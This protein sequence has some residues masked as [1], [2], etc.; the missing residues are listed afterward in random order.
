M[1]PPPPPKVRRNTRGMSALYNEQPPQP[2]YQPPPPHSPAPAGELYPG[3]SEWG[4]QFFM[5]APP[6]VS[7]GPPGG[8]PGLRYDSYNTSH[9]LAELNNSGRSLEM[10]GQPTG[11]LNISSISP[12]SPISRNGSVFEGG[13]R[14][15]TKKARPSKKGKRSKKTRRRRRQRGGAMYPNDDNTV[16]LD[17]EDDSPDSVMR[18][19]SYN[20]TIDNPIASQNSSV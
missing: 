1:E 5:E 11:A 16:I 13:R 15:R 12:I 14:K 6:Y 17:R 4:P 10:E 3:E 2:H 18:V 8:S 20:S 9:I 7:P 19:R